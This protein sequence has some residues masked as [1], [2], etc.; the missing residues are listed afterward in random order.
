MDN[1]PHDPTADR[2]ATGAF[3]ALIMGLAVIFSVSLARAT[4][5]ASGLP[6][7]LPATCESQ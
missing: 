7:L 3:V 5:V 2:R 1:R 6:C 4:P